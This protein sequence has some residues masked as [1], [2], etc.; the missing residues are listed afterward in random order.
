[1]L[2][3]KDLELANS[4]GS[5]FSAIIAGR[6]QLFNILIHAADDFASFLRDPLVQ[7]CTRGGSDAADQ[8]DGYGT[9]ATGTA[10]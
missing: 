1:V 8:A 4:I 6:K 3:Y 2:K 5:F 7:V 10:L 9:S